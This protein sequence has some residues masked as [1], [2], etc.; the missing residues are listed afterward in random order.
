MLIAHWG[1]GHNDLSGRTYFIDGRRANSLIGHVP[2]VN[3]SYCSRSAPV[4]RAALDLRMLREGYSLTGVRIVGQVDDKLG[5][6]KPDVKIVITG[7]KG[8]TESTTDRAGIFDLTNMPAGQY[9]I[10]VEGCDD[11]K[12]NR[13]YRCSDRHG[14]VLQ[15]GDV[16]GV[17]LLAD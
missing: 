6:P 2:I 12:N 4:D 16:W 9:A 17:E 1:I 11:N 13:F 10:R 3:I 7:P 14:S 5:R 8:N 15:A